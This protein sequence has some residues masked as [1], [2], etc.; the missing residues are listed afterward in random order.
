MKH[1]K[2]ILGGFYFWSFIVVKA[3]GSIELILCMGLHEGSRDFLT[4][5]IFISCCENHAH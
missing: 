3:H 4:N 2:N 5:Q 1:F